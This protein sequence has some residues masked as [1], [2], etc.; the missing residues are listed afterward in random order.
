MLHKSLFAPYARFITAWGRSWGRVLLGLCVWGTVVGAPSG[1]TATPDMC[2][3]LAIPY[4]TEHPVY[5]Q[6]LLPWAQGI[7]EQSKGNIS[8][9]IFDANTL[10]IE[11]DA[12]APLVTGALEIGGIMPTSMFPTPPVSGLLN[13]YLDAPNAHAASRMVWDTV[14]YHKALQGELQLVHLL[15]AWASSPAYIHSTSKPIRTATDMQGVKF[16]VWSNM[17]EK[18]VAAMGGIPLRCLPAETTTLLRKGLAEGVLCPVTPL[19]S[20]GIDQYITF[21]TDFPLEYLSFYMGMNQQIW[22]ALPPHH[23]KIFNDTTGRTM[24]A[25]C[26]LVLDA[27]EHAVRRKLQAQ[28]HTFMPPS[29]AFQLEYRK[30]MALIRQTQ[31]DKVNVLNI[32]G[33][34]EFSTLLQEI[35]LD[36]KR[37]DSGRGHSK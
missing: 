18:F 6:V 11:A 27:G 19:F 21:T 20:F 14:Q 28:G 5:Q 36:I 25:R 1:M 16:L 23:K 10:L 4:S 30:H 13:Y 31:A 35:R 24:S 2:L 26:G 8:I 17:M 9:D 32:A 12:Y 15:W 34:T 3:T 22:D 7:H 37:E 29:E 33:M